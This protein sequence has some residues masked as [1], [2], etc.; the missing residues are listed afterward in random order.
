M[1]CSSKQKLLCGL[2]ECKICFDRSFASYEGKTPNDKLK[3]D[4]WDNEKNGEIK[5]INICKG[6]HKKYWFKCDNCLHCSAIGID[7]I[8]RE[9]SSWCSYCSNPPKKLCDDNRCQI[10]FDKSLASYDGKTPTGQ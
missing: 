2:Q 4:C 5:P 3:V 6:T 9:S 7:K 10:C 8:N 1:I